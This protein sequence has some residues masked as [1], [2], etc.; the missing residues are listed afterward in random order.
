MS[1]RKCSI[2]KQVGHNVRTC[3]QAKKSDSAAASAE[4]EVPA[5]SGS[6]SSDTTTIPA[7][8]SPD[9]KTPQRK[10]S[11]PPKRVTP[12]EAKEIIEI[13][14]SDASM[15]Q[16]VAAD[17]EFKPP[18]SSTDEVQTQQVSDPKAKGKTAKQESGK[19]S[20]VTPELDSRPSSAKA[21]IATSN[22]R[23]M[24]PRSSKTKAV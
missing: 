18:N 5:L 8:Q 14:N 12:P 2:C 17:F 19:L 3:P 23:S 22:K 1:Q 15:L 20:E 21:G 10:K 7:T 4:S 9:P 6:E 13:L 16:E 24:P 11:P